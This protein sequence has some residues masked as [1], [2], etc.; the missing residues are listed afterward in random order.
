M[1]PC[2]VNC[3]RRPFLDPFKAIRTARFLAE[4]VPEISRW[5]Q[6]HVGCSLR[7]RATAHCPICDR[8]PKEPAADRKPVC[9][10]GGSLV[11]GPIRGHRLRI[12]E[13]QPGILLRMG[14]EMETAGQEMIGRNNRI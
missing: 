1:S 12:K 11:E 6:H 3:A 4:V 2:E 13:I 8:T 10:C 5:D 9:Q 7:R 14:S